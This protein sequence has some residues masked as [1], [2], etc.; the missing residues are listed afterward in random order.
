MADKLHTGVVVVM[1]TE[2]TYHYWESA[3]PLLRSHDFDPQLVTLHP[4]GSLHELLAQAGVPTRGLGVRSSRDYVQGVFRLASAI[5]ESKCAVV[6]CSEAIAAALGG[7]AARISGNV[8]C[9]FH[10]H[11]CESS[12]KRALFTAIASRSCRLTVAV[13]QASAGYAMRQNGL[14]PERVKVSYNGIPPLRGV[15]EDE[16]LALRTSLGIPAD[17]PVI[18]MVARL[19]T[20]KGHPT[21][22]EALAPV[23]AK[24]GRLPHVLVVGGGP[25]E[26]RLRQRAASIQHAKIHWIGHT[27]DVAPYYRAANVAVVPSYNEA[28]GLVAVEAMSCGVPLIASATDGLL[29]VVE[30]GRSGV[31]V[32]PRDVLALATAIVDVLCDPILRE[33]LIAGG[34]ERYLRRFTVEAMVNSWVECYHHVLSRAAGGRTAAA[35]SRIV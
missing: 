34:R 6:H 9:I 1:E 3:I 30:H 12:G 32:A 4:P 27:D 29:E 31:L 5:R 33:R 26:E 18:T 2:G 11:H 15:S 14:P 23:H 22:F 7:L 24:L 19:R 21:L 10:R 8:P 35:V 16:I 25:E 20:V 17:A 28:F 13:S